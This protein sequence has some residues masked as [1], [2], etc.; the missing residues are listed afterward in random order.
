MSLLGLFWEIDF[1]VE[2]VGGVV[3]V[4]LLLPADVVLALEFGLLLGELLAAGDS[5]IG[6]LAGLADALLEGPEVQH[7]LH[8]LLQAGTKA[9]FE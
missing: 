1:G 5:Q 7:V 9:G 2:R 6:L 8:L 4:A 3:G